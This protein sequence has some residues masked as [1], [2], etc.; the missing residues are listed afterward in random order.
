MARHEALYGPSSDKD[1]DQLRDL[2]D[3]MQKQLALLTRAVDELKDERK[4]LRSSVLALADGSR[5]QPQSQTVQPDVF[6]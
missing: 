2:A 5:A 3:A 6:K 4:S 1:R